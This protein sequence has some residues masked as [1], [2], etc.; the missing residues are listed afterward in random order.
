LFLIINFPSTFFLYR[1][2]FS[3]AGINTQ[4]LSKGL[5]GI[6][7][8]MAIAS[9][10]TGGRSRRGTGRGMMGAPGAGIGRSGGGIGSLIS[11]LSGGRGYKSMGG[12]LPNIFNSQGSK[13]I[14]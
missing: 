6:L 5:L 11:L 10:L 12:L 7:A 2:Y 13:R 14:F 4:R 1:E 8:P 9:L 3:V